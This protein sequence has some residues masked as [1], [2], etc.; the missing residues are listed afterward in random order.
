MVHFFLGLNSEEHFKHVLRFYYLHHA[1]TPS[2]TRPLIR[3]LVTFRSIIDKF[4]GST[5]LLLYF[6]TPVYMEKLMEV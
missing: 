4:T 5:Q 6:F 1:C 3:E 2:E